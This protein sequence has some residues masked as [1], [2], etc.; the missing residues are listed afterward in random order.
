[1]WL[2]VAFGGNR[3]D[4]CA[5]KPELKLIFTVVPLEKS[6]NVK[7]LKNSDRFHAGVNGSRIC[8]HPWAID[9]HYER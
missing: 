1:M 3:K 4:G 5:A 2:L 9:W 8:N 7:Y 6:F